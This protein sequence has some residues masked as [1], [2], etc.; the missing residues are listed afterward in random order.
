MIDKNLRNEL[1]IQ[2][3]DNI[4][5]SFN[6]I[7]VKP[8]DGGD[9]N[10][11][12]KISDMSRSYFLKINKC[13]YHDMFEAEREALIEINNKCVIKVPKVI[14]AGV[15]KEHAYIIMEFIELSNVGSW[16]DCGRKLAMMHKSFGSRFGWHRDNTIGLTPQF[17]KL[18]KCWISF[19]NNQRLKYQ[20]EIAEK[21]GLKLKGADVLLKNID[22][23]FVEYDPKPSLLHGDLWS[24]NIS[25][26]RLGNPVL[27]DPA[28]YY[29]DRECDIAMTELF[30]SFPI[31]FYDAYNKEWPLDI[32][33][34]RRKVLYQLYHVLNHYNMFRG[35]YGAQ[36]EN[37]ISFLI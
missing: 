34:K 21:S 37:M 20:F 17:N 1:N 13:R 32:G 7:G 22:N 9:I 5:S 36:A 33:Y 10:Q 27:Y 18:S 2:L 15:Y 19:Y 29:G 12:Y 35:S 8:I 4:D 3:S 31:E 6:I 11:S 16:N 25:F 26:D 30:G 24:G 28:L 23:F 14:C